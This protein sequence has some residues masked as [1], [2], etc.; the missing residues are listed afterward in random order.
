MRKI[1]LFFLLVFISMVTNVSI[2]S[3]LNNMYKEGAS[4]KVIMGHDASGSPIL[5]D[6]Q[7]GEPHFDYDGDGITDYTKFEHFYLPLEIGGSEACDDLQYK[8]F[9]NVSIYSG[10]NSGE[11]LFQSEPI[12]DNCISINDDPT[13]VYPA[14]WRGSIGYGMT[15]KELVITPQ[16][17]DTGWIVK[18]NSIPATQ[19]FYTSNSSS[20]ADYTQAMPMLQPSAGGLSYQYGAMPNNGLIIEINGES[21]YVAA[22][23]GRFMKYSTDPNGV[24]QLEADTPFLHR[25]DLVGR[26]YGLLAHDTY[27][28]EDKVFLVSGITSRDLFSDV[29]S[30][31]ATGV[32][33]GS[34]IWA[35][36]ERHVSILDMGSNTVQ[37]KFYSYAHDNQDGD[38]YRQRVTYP[39]YP[40]IPTGEDPRGSRLIYNVFD[41]ASWAIHISTPGETSSAIA[42]ANYYVWDVIRVNDNEVRI[43]TSPIDNQKPVWIPDFMSESVIGSWRQ[44]F[45]FP[46]METRI[47]TWHG[48]RQT[49]EAGK[50][51]H[52]GIPDLTV[53]IP[54]RENTNT[55]NG[56]H[57]P[58][59]RR[60]DEGTNDIILRMKDSS[61]GEFEESMF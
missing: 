4:W 24:N 13:V 52:G 41:G 10:T 5:S 38:T 25:D 49:F 51:I 39:S 15:E 50:V 20:F 1:H 22:S 7:F 61:G 3:E 18:A 26:N 56:W 9:R 8:G 23:S 30:Y 45:Y 46:K 12:Q 34:D 48:D 53:P 35:S 43:V 29:M 40:L 44:E 16:Y 31:Y 6:S 54:V 42:I 37:Q 11:L 55:S 27:G 33:L 19:A 60:I 17:Y 32:V 36:I 57:F 28:N 21:K 2:A 14:L 47:F 59:Q 58:T